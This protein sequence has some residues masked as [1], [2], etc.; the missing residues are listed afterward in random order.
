MKFDPAQW[1]AI[2]S[3]LG[4]ALDLDEPAR[5]AWLARLAG[6]DAALAPLLR[7]LL[8]RHAT[9][10]SADFLG[11]LPRIDDT[12]ESSGSGVAVGAVVGAYRLLRVL[13]R[14]GMGEVWLAERADGMLKRPVALKLP[15]VAIPQRALAERFAREREILARLTHPQHC[16]PVRR[17]HRRR[18][19]ALSRARVCRRRDDHAPLRREQAGCPRAHRTVP[20][21]ADRRRSSRTATWCCTGT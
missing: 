2:S 14:G 15:I 9:A 21:G 6:E 3:L 18:R 1:S 17:R 7:E 20:A 19:P 12:A 10:E 13:G 16:A 5:T 8:A 4:Q 11:T